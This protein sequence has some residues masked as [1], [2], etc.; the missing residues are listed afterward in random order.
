MRG[1]A[2]ALA[3]TIAIAVAGGCG[4]GATT[5]PSATTGDARPSPTAA[6]STAAPSAASRG[7]SAAT[8]QTDTS[9]GRIWDGLPRGFPTFPGSTVADDAGVTGVSATWAVRNGDPKAIADWFQRALEGATY[10]TEALSG[11]NEDG[12]FVLDSVGE[13]GCKIETVVAPSGGLMLVTVKYGA[14]CPNA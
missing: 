7:P 6:I 11:P 12:S 14:A 3:A 9:W 4:P 10:S 1:R 8:A 5:G 2:I 13:A